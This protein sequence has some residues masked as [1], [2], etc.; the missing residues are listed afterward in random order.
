MNGTTFGLV[1]LQLGP[2]IGVGAM[3]TVLRARTRHGHPVAVKLLLPRHMA[4]PETVAAFALEATV[5]ASIASPYVPAVLGTGSTDD[6]QPF[7]VMDLLHG[8]DL[9][10]VLGTRTNGLPRR[11][12][13]DSVIDACH[14]A[15]ALHRAGLVHRDIKPANLFLAERP[16]GPPRVMLIDLGIAST[17][18]A[19]TSEAAGPSNV[20]GSADYMAP[21][22][23]DASRPV[24]ATS[25]VWSLGV[26]L[27]ELLTGKTPFAASPGPVP[28]ALAGT[29]DVDAVTPAGLGE[30]VARC[31]SRPPPSRFS[32]ALELADAL[33]PYASNPK[34]TPTLVPPPHADAAPLGRRN[35]HDHPWIPPYLAM[36]RPTM[37]SKRFACLARSRPSMIVLVGGVARLRL[38]TAIRGDGRGFARDGALGLFGGALLFGRAFVVC[39][40]VA[41]ARGPLPDVDLVARVDDRLTRRE[42]ARVRP[43]VCAVVVLRR[44]PDRR[45]R[46]R[47]KQNDKCAL[48][49]NLPLENGES[50]AASATQRRADR[51]R[52]SEARATIR[53]TT[54]VDDERSK[55]TKA[56]ER[57]VGR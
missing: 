48:H 7:I 11:E 21:E 35:G 50:L 3:A 1:D 23:F 54:T 4:N 27:F 34:D 13:V 10:H 2:V 45:E 38:G 29:V 49:R 15:D 41:R 40:V 16:V 22:C 30:V 44:A 32:S 14:G 57:D 17:T 51:T 24:D 53:V 5:Q 42:R 28:S 47:S 52:V 26:V 9:A 8:A 20:V 33:Q 36:P 55:S 25:D 18:S 19:T 31:L 46:N 43:R 39:D 6:G 56:G 37:E 12:A